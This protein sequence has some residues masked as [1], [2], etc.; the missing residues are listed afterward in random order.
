[1]LETNTIS[2]A[3]SLTLRILEIPCNIRLNTPDACAPVPGLI[4]ET[5]NNRIICAIQYWQEYPDIRY[6]LVPNVIPENPVQHDTTSLIKSPFDLRRTK[7][8]FCQPIETDQHALINTKTQADWVA[9]MVESLQIQSIFLFAPAFHMV[10]AYLTFLKSFTKICSQNIIMIPHLT[11]L[12]PFEKILGKGENLD[13]WTRMVDE[14][15]RIH[16]YQA[17]GDV[18]T[19]EELRNYLAWLYEEPCLIP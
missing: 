19:I 13:S 16:T 14:I 2:E 12:V 3:V 6:L 1:M 17:N 18:A 5:E 15:E 10:R 4:G 7:G 11:P 9:N 8:V